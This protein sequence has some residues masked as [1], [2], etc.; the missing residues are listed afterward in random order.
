[1]SLRFWPTNS[2]LLILG[3]EPHIG[4]CIV[5]TCICFGH[6]T[7]SLLQHPR[8]VGMILGIIYSA[9]PSPA[10]TQSGHSTLSFSS[11]RLPGVM[12]LPFMRVFK[13]IALW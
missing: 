9:S 8:A 13:T 6:G 1:M 2:L 7:S 12:A 11:E 4:P 3:I 5:L 10:S